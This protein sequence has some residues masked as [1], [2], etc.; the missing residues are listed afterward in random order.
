[1]P[2]SLSSTV[3]SLDEAIEKLASVAAEARLRRK[4]AM[5]SFSDALSALK[6][7]AAAHPTAALGLGGAALG[8]LYGGLTSLGQEPE[9]RQPLSRA[10]TGALA[11][12]AAG[13]GAGVLHEHLPALLNG[14]S[15]TT[16]PA[17]EQLGPGVFYHGGKKMQINPDTPGLPELNQKVHDL[18]SR[19]PASL[20]VGKVTDW[21]NTYAKNHPILAGIAGADAMSHVGGRLAERFNPGGSM[22]PQHLSA[23][24]RNEFTEVASGGGGLKADKGLGKRLSDILKNSTNADLQKIMAGVR[25]GHGLGGDSPVSAEYLRRMIEQGTPHGGRLGG[26]RSLMDVG[27]NIAKGIFPNYKPDPLL[28][29]GYRD[30]SKAMSNSTALATQ[31]RTWWHQARTGAPNIEA[32]PGM[33]NKALRGINR[34][35]APQGPYARV[36]GRLGLYAGIP[37]AMWFANRQRQNSQNNEAVQQLMERVLSNSNS[38]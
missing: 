17:A 1:M 7:Q 35:Q 38:Q 33:L 4:Y 22:N 14:Q 27:Q 34:I 37:L 36:G 9:E 20:G 8:G 2:A 29:T 21:M 24:I 15:S 31:P 11:G 5:P 10:F 26:F 23:G 3:N 28:G 19:D 32:A 25:S 16:M 30:T 18:M 12:G 6:S 13:L